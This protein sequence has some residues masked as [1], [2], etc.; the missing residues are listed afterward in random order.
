M[1]LR[2]KNNNTLKDYKNGAF[3]KSYTTGLDWSAPTFYDGI[4]DY[5][6]FWASYHTCDAVLELVAQVK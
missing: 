2:Q 3:Y 4:T 5:L 6:T 1:L